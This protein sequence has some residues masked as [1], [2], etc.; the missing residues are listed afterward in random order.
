MT[1]IRKSMRPGRPVDRSL[2]Q[3]RREEILAAATTFFARHGYQNADIEVLAEEIG[4]G[5]GTINRYFPTKDKLFRSALQRGLEAL[6]AAIEAQKQQHSGRMDD[7][8]D[9]IC[10]AVIAYFTYFDQHP[11]II[12]LI[13][14]E[15][16]EFKGRGKPTYFTHRDKYLGPWQQRLRTL[17]A[18]GVIRTMDVDAITSCLGMLMYGALVTHPFISGKGGLAAQARGVLDV[19]LGGIRAAAPRGRL[20]RS[21]P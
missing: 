4:V 10:V 16:A 7:G 20:R 11:E 6:Y 14:L 19:V 21:G 5:K 13:V 17:M 15:R 3:R 2:P 9:A 1:S 12:E 8:L 18:K